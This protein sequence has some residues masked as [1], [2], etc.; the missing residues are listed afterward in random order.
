MDKPFAILQDW[1]KEGRIHLSPQPVPVIDDEPREFPIQPLPDGLSDDAL[2]EHAMRDVKALGWSLVPLQ[3]R[4]PVEIQPQDE[5][6]DALRARSNSL[7]ETAASTFNK[8]ANISKVP[9]IQED[10]FTWTICGPAGFPSKRMWT[11]MG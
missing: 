7:Y 3:N 9:F 4:S 10:G 5:E 11:C 2:F 8:R 1:V 6:Q